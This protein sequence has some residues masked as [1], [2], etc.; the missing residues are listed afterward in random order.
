MDKDNS[1]LLH[2][3][4]GALAVILMVY[5][6]EQIKVCKESCY[7]MKIS[8]I[9][10]AASLVLIILSLWFAKKSMYHKDVASCV[11]EEEIRGYQ[12]AL[13]DVYNSCNWWITYSS[14]FFLVIAIVLFCI[15]VC[16]L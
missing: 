8:T 3:L 14:L 15:G 1:N 6:G 16:L 9:T 7:I 5:A 12:L 11:N 4:I 10:S 13:Q 2:T